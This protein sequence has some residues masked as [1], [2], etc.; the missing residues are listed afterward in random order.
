MSRYIVALKGD[1]LYIVGGWMGYSLGNTDRNG[2]SLYPMNPQHSPHPHVNDST[3]F[4]DPVLRSLNVSKSFKT[5]LNNVNFIRTEEVPDT[6]SGV[7]DA[8]FF[9]TESGFDLT[10]GRRQPYNGTIYGKEASTQ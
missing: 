5:S 1:M 6:V 10:F 7:T 9:P 4:P 8:A 2:P 3:T